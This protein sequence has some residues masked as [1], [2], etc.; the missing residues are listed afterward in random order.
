MTAA[1]GTLARWRAAAAEA[2]GGTSEE[3]LYDAALAWV[4]AGGLS[5]RVLDYGAGTG[6]LVRLLC[7]T[8]RFDRVVGAD[9][10]ARE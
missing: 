2:S 8:G 4:E 3:A 1:D 10:M 7:Q 6:T 5:G 9:L